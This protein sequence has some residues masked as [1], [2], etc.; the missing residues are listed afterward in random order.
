MDLVK[1]WSNKVIDKTTELLNQPRDLIAAVHQDQFVKGKKATSQCNQ[2]EFCG[3][4]KFAIKP[5]RLDK[6]FKKYNDINSAWLKKQEVETDP[7]ILHGLQTK[8]NQMG[9]QIVRLEKR[10]EKMNK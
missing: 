4:G 3:L 10:V 7:I 5:N 2:V 6:L 9:R 8:L 1:E